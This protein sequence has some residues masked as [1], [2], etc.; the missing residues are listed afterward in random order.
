LSRAKQLAAGR[1]Y[2]VALLED[3][4]VMAWGDRVD[5]KLGDGETGPFSDGQSKIPTPRPVRGLSGVKQI[6]EIYRQMKGQCGDYQGAKPLA[7]GLTGHM[8]GDDPPGVGLLSSHLIAET[9]QV[10]FVSEV[11]LSMG[12]LY[13][14]VQDVLQGTERFEPKEA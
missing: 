7:R 9:A 3:G 2:A 11:L 14:N 1:H 6:A 5:G 10:S 12:W 8:G 4:T 13:H